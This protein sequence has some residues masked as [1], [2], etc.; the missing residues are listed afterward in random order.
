MAHDLLPVLGGAAPAAAGDA[1]PGLLEALGVAVYTTDAEGRLTSY[2][3]AA[4]ALWG[5]RPPLG[6]ARWCGSWRLFVPDGTPLP[7]AECPMAVA[8]R[9]G[10]P[11][12]GAE[13]VAER[14]NGTRV[15]FIPYPT[16]LRDGAGALVGA[17][18]VLVDI[19][20]RKAAEAALAGSEACLRAVFETTP[21][22]IK[23]V[24]P[25]GTLLRMNAAGLRMVEATIPAEAEGRCVFDL[26]APE[27]RA[28]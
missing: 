5:W 16:P 23:L 13:A 1:H 27:H 15:P 18:N 8:L 19:S 14:P 20:G 21:E 24:A 10:R 28:A 7:H 12:R 26:I 4:V 22:C 9:E 6:D 2:N 3:T 17:V 11:V 25:D